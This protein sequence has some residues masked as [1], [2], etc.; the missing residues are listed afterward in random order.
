MF[1]NYIVLAW[2]NILRAKVYSI[3]NMTGLA[4]GVSCCLLLALYI[5]DEMSYDKHHARLDDLYILSSRF[6]NDASGNSD[7]PTLSP[8]IA[9]AFGREIPEFES[10]ARMVSAGQCL[11]TTGENTF[12]EKGGVVADATLFDVLTFTF[13]EGSPHKALTEPNTVVVTDKLAQKLFGNTTALNKLVTI[14]QNGYPPV[15]FRVSAVIKD[16]PKSY[17]YIS[18]ITSMASEGYAEYLRSDGLMNEWAGQNFFYGVAKLSPGHSRADVEKKM[19]AVLQKYGAEQLNA[20]SMSKTLFLYPLKDYY[21]KS[22]MSRSPRITYLYVIGSI[23]AFILLIACINFMNLSTARAGKRAAEIGIRKVMGA[24]RGTLVRHILTEAMV[25][26]VFAI[27]ISVVLVEISL[28]L[29]NRLTDKTITLDTAHTPY[30]VGA[31]IA[32][33]VVTGLVAGSYPALHLSAIEPVRALRGNHLMG[34]GAGWLRRGLVVFQFVI[35]IALV[36]G[37][38]IITRQLDY[39]QTKDLGFD[40][41]AR[42]VLPLRTAEAKGQYENLRLA[43][44]K[45]GSIKAVSAADYA[46][47]MRI[48][49][50]MTFYKEGGSMQNAIGNFRN[51]ISP[52]YIELLNMHLL[53][54][55]SFTD[56]IEQESEGKVIINRTSARKF[57]F[58]P[59]EAIGQH[60]YFDWQGQQHAH[61][62]IGVV[63]D[64]H[65]TSIKDAIEPVMFFIPGEAGYYGHMLVS[66]DAKDFQ[67]T[68]AVM[69]KTWKSLVGSTP[70]EYTFLDDNIRNQYTED[71]RVG[72]IITGFTCIAVL[73]SCLGLYG[74]SSYMAERRIKEI[75]VRKVM[76]ASIGQI[77]QLISSEFVRLVVIAVVISIP[78]AWYGMD[79]WLRGFAYHTTIDALVFA[80][81]GGIALLIAL[82]TVSFESLRAA[83]GNPLHALRS[84]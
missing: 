7:S 47:G 73:I 10:T 62:I 50:D 5:Q 80:Y 74:L 48:F 3:I 78:L 11:F 72:D 34:H 45:N 57:G 1:Y 4:L 29:F 19:N 33:A 9:V 81:A 6:D 61:E 63:E 28:P 15:N 84:E 82:V 59:G 58:E 77:V 54:G 53:A 8:P 40:A 69:E 51:K 83:A 39:M 43:L 21:L 70:F 46:P 60:V 44:L 52:G 24:Y 20:R 71:R 64:Y 66:V 14:S 75:G 26:V 30:F 65:Q 31:L 79:Q 2:R 42:I 16:Q 13:L 12:Y 68:I 17:K 22:A 55:R 37:M 23:A 67:R 36:S 27:L 76:G 41:D 35:A 32:L 49:S 25:I 38:I 56:N 18:F